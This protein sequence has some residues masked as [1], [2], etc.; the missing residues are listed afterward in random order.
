MQQIRVIG[1]DIAKTVFQVH[2]VDRG[3]EVLIAKSLKRK[4]VLAF[5]SKVSPCLVGMEACGTAFH[6]AREITK[7]GHTVKLMPPKYVKAYVKRGKTD[8]GD[9]AAICEA[10]S[11]PSMTFVPIKSAENQAI[12]MLHSTRQ[13]LIGQR[14]QSINSLRGHLAEF[15]IVAPQGLIGVAALAGIVRDECDSRLPLAARVALI[16]VVAQIEATSAEIAKLDRAIAADHK[17]SE[18]SRNLAT[19]PSV[20]AIVATAIRAR[21]P[22]PHGFRNGR[23]MAAWLGLVPEQDSSAGKT[24]QKGISKKG[25]R[26]LRQLL[27]TGAMAVIRQARKR[28]DKHPWLTKLLAR[29][30]PKVAA[31]ALANKTARIAWAILV[32]GGTYQSEHRSRGGPLPAL[33]VA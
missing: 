11:R 18:T 10:V 7:C 23:H 8:A 1:L 31:V 13:L 15:G 3:G 26:Y 25:D 2:A 19:I 28:P 20:G 14:T 17:A 16:P 24:K 6:W 4:G 27:V 30:H 21:I 33:V 29:T 12:A 32:R 22:N 9:A 5:F